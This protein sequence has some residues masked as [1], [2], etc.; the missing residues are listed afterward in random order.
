MLDWPQEAINK[1]YRYCLEQRV[2]PKLDLDKTIRELVGSRD[3]VIDLIR[4]FVVVD[5]RILGS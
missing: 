5:W 3:A 1:Y 4:L 2:I